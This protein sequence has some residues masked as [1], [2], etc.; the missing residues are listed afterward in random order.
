MVNKEKTIGILGG[1][2]P[3]A[4]VDLFRKIVECTPAKKDWE[5]LRV[6]VDNNP[7]IPSRT[8]AILFHEEDPTPK[9]IETA[10][11]LER[12][13]ADFIIIPCN[14][15]HVF[16]EGLSKAVKVPIL[17]IIA[18][19]VKYV[20]KSNSKLKTVGLLAAKI[21]IESKLY[22]KEFHD[23][24]ITTVVLTDEEQKIV[25]NIIEKVKLDDTCKE[26]TALLRKAIKILL[27]KGAEVIIA[28]CTEISILAKSDKYPLRI[29]DS[30]EI[31][32]KSAVSYAKN[33]K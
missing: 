2:G 31:L 26:T 19:T 1:M 27:H 14:S 17:N 4:T 5:H 3:Y 25:R 9:L 8:R 30:N 15:A 22:Q 32:A 10:K 20:K 24:G 16:Y 7:K 28:G 23:V 13:G 21:V 18:E 29:F 12:A 11:N 33:A 6:I